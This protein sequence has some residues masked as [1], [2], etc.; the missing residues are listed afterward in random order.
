MSNRKNGLKNQT[1][2]FFC[3]VNVGL[4]FFLYYFKLCAFGEISGI[5]NA[6]GNFRFY[7][8]NIAVLFPGDRYPSERKQIIR[9]SFREAADEAG[10]KL[11]LRRRFDMKACEPSNIEARHVTHKVMVAA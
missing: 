2:F 4:H 3:F 8:V 1:V 10:M 7:A 6:C 9:A 5:R 11:D